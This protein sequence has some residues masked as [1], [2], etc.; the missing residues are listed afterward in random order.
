MHKFGI[1]IENIGVNTEYCSDSN[2]IEEFKCE[3]N[4]GFDGKRCENECIL[5]CGDNGICTS[6]INDTTG[7]KQWECLCTDN[8]TGIYSQDSP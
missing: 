1:D 3:C 8:F 7:T 4:A 6:Q 5:E 2:G